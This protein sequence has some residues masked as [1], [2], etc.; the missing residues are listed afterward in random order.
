M[1]ETGLITDDGRSVAV[2]VIIFGTGFHAD[3]F[4][5]PMEITGV[6]GVKLSEEWADGPR[7]FKGATVPG[8]PNLF[9]L[10]GP[11]TNIVVWVAA[12]SFSLNVR[13][14]T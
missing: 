6:G 14:A 2:D 4:L 7:A 12:L 13:C 5:W 9:C 8:F 10:Y 1:T 11:N 3:R